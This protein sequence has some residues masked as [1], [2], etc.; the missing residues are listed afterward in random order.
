M[1]SRCVQKRHIDDAFLKIVGNELNELV[2]KTPLANHAASGSALS[3]LMI[4][5]PFTT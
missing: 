5:F 1:H 4:A 2:S 3:S